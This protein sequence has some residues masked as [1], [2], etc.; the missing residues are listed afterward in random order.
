M[1]YNR[2]TAN[3]MSCGPWAADV[4]MFI[5]PGNGYTALSGASWAYCVNGAGTNPTS[6]T[7]PR[8]TC[9]ANVETDPNETCRFSIALICF[10]LH[11]TIH[12]CLPQLELLQLVLQVMINGQEAFATDLW[13]AA[14]AS[15]ASPP[16]AAATSS[17][18]AAGLSGAPLSTRQRGS[19]AAGE[20][21]LVRQRVPRGFP[22]AEH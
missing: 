6:A 9:Y 13:L 17:M 11:V 12:S 1:V 14:P 7:S 18:N 2:R 20:A 15:Q 16:S 22:H 10:R 21:R 8:C 3:A 19:S 4:P 5:D